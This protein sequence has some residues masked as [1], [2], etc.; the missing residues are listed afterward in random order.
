MNI[1]EQSRLRQWAQDMTNQKAS[2]L[3]TKKG[4]IVPQQTGALALCFYQR[5]CRQTIS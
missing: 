2:A 5:I 1:N 3:T 4:T